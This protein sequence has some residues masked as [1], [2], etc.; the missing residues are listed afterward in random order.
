MRRTCPWREAEDSCFGG[1]FELVNYLEI[2]QYSWPDKYELWLMNKK[3][4]FSGKN[5][6]IPEN[7]LFC[8][9]YGDD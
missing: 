2:S 6:K 7:Y 8:Y 1:F 5:K 4:N 9:F 3:Q